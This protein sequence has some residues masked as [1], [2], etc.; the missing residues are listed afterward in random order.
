MAQNVERKLIR[1]GVL[2]A[3]VRQQSNF[4]GSY[5]QGSYLMNG[6]KHYGTSTTKVT[7]GPHL[8]G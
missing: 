5:W 8:Q 3:L 7:Q 2:K 1:A 6:G 4:M